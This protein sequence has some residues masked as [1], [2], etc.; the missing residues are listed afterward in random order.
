M[1]QRDVK[2]FKLQIINSVANDLNIKKIIFP[3]TCTKL[4]IDLLTNVAIG[5]GAHLSSEMVSLLN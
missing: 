5:K 4:T 2:I 3:L 1:I